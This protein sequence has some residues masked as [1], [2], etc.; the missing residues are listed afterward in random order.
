MPS[1]T[2]VQRSVAMSQVMLPQQS[3]S[4]RQRTSRSTQ[5]ECE[6][7]VSERA[8]RSAPQHSLAV[9][10]HVCV[11][12]RQPVP[13]W[14]EPARQ[15]SSSQHSMSRSQSPSRS[16]H[17]HSPSSQSMRP[18]QSS[19]SSHEVLPPA[20]HWRTGGAVGSVRVSLH[21]RPGQH[22]VEPMQPSRTSLHIIMVGAGRHMNVWQVEPSQHSEESR[23]NEPSVPHAQVP[24]P[25]QNMRPQ[26]SSEFSQAP[27][28]PMQHRGISGAGRHTDPEQHS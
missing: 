7:I 20:Q 24:S 17:W 8:H 6:P 5:Q 16:T 10:S 23:Q 28:W 26:Q 22:S 14:H 12:R 19:F 13:S 4:L 21:D 27:P 18:Q 11:S 3:M 15:M 1:G 25:P 9:G 2:A